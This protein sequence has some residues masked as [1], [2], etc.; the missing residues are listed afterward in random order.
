MSKQLCPGCLNDRLSEQ[1]LV[2][3]TLKAASEISNSI[4][5]GISFPFLLFT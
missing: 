2:D 3:R 5:N 4:V 1:D